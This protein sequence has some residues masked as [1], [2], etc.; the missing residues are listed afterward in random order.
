MQ[1]AVVDIGTGEGLLGLVSSL[2]SLICVGRLFGSYYGPQTDI[3]ELNGLGMA[4]VCKG[5]L[6]CA[7]E[8]ER[9]GN[10]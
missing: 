6:C 2:L 3:K 5:G 8:G 1:L 9:R 4:I 7:I 10:N